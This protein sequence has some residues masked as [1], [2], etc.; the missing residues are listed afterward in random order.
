MA[1]GAALATLIVYAYTS[2]T[3][4]WG[5]GPEIIKQ[6]ESESNCGCHVTL[7]NGGDGGALLSR[8]KLEGAKTSAD[9]V[10]G[11]D[12]TMIHKYKK[13]LQWKDAKFKLFDQAPYAF[14]Y[15][16]KRVSSPPD[17]L[18]SLLD[19]KWKGRVVIEDPRLSTTGL[20]LLLWVVKEKGD[21]AWDYFRKLKPQ[22]K[23]VAPSWDLAY[24]LF[25][26]GEAD[27]V[28]SYWTSPAYH[29]QEEKNADYKAA[30]FTGGQY[31]Q[32]EYLAIVPQSAQ[33]KLADDFA[34]FM[35][36]PEVQS[37]MPEK[38]FMYPANRKAKLTPAFKE[39]G[40][41]HELSPLKPQQLEHL[42]EWLAM[43]REIFS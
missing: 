33:Q 31:F 39:L 20:G 29:I 11:I 10:V 17:S 5:P 6:F 35:L 30:K 7:V 40:H 3:S 25:K 43:W 1:S 12:E 15:N 8:L 27:L 42:E 28:F 21:G 9:V 36:K 34:K 26:K 4:A 14:V 19:P 41:A 37:L 18:D 38:N 23:L 13:E 2:F 32:R 16:S 24:G 22:V